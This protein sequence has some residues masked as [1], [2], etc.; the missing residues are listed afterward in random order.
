M[1]QQETSHHNHHNHHNHYKHHEPLE[2]LEVLSGV[3]E[4]KL[5][6][7]FAHFLVPLDRSCLAGEKAEG[8]KKRI[9]YVQADS[10]MS[11]DMILGA[12]F[13]AGLER[14]AWQKIMSLLP[15]SSWRWQLNSVIKKEMAATRF[16]VVEEIKTEHVHRHLAEILEMIEKAAF[17][18]AVAKLAANIFYRLA[19]AEG[20]VHGISPWQV[21][22]HEVGA[23]DSI[24][25]VVGFACGV[26]LL[27]IDEIVCSPLPVS[28]GEIE[29]AHG[30]VPLPAPAVL[31][32]LKD[33]PVYDKPCGKEL[34]T[35]TGAAILRTC[36][37]GFGG[38]PPMTVK[39]VGFGSGERELPWANVLRVVLGEEEALSLGQREEQNPYFSVQREE[40]IPEESASMRET[41]KNM[42]CAQ[43]WCCGHILAV[44]FHM[45][46]MTGEGL[47]FLWNQ[48]FAAGAVDAYYI[49]I[50]MKKGRPG[51][52]VTVL[53]EEDFLSPVLKSIFTHSTTLGVRID[54]KERVFLRRGTVVVESPWGP[55]QLKYHCWQ[56]HLTVKAEYDWCK[57]IG[58]RE[59][60]PLSR[61]HHWA[62]TQGKEAVAAILAAS[63]KEEL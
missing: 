17:P 26:Y 30:R 1:K 63:V 32:L 49:P 48:L 24:V 11:G 16:Q 44:E 46:D 34:V 59:G 37:S 57:K 27:G 9:C 5:S 58:E 62:N 7:R 52:A 39:R 13:D 33:V 42:A 22:F 3:E 40:S 50:Q 15:F 25:D 41:L 20:R 61:I 8:E 19:E 35:P 55:L 51:V 28:L 29:I 6:E 14:E 53:V 45:D 18:P 2:H 31:V 12:L 10:G 38:M 23:V 36:A 4:A 60:I 21:H 54:R 56:D 47:G 43:D